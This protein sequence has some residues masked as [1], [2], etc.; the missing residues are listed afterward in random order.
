MHPEAMILSNIVSEDA[1]SRDVD[2]GVAVARKVGD[3][4]LPNPDNAHGV[5]RE[6][7]V[8]LVGGVMREDECGTLRVDESGDLKEGWLV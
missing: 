5:V 3:G 4:L 6:E 2:R 8:E 1:R 7:L